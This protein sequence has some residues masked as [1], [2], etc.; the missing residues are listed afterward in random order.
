[1]RCVLLLVVS[2]FS[3]RSIADEQQAFPFKTVKEA[4]IAVTKLPG[5]STRSIGGWLVVSDPPN[6]TTWTFSTSNTVGHPSMIRRRVVSKD[7]GL[8]IE[9]RVLCE[10]TE[11]ACRELAVQVASLDKEASRRLTDHQ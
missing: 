3:S 10:A 8:A 6:K 7:G 1:M 9:T 5:V 11:S 2:F 4:R